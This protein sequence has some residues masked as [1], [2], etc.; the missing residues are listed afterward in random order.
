MPKRTSFPQ[1]I[2][3]FDFGMRH[4]GMAVGQLIT[5]SATSLNPIQARDGIP[6]WAELD[7]IIKQWP[8]DSIVIGVPF[9]MDETEQTITFAARKFA[10]RLHERYQLPVYEVDERLTTVEAKQQLY[11]SGKCRGKSLN[12]VD[13][14]AAKLIVEDWLRNPSSEFFH[15]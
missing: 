3:G 6:D 2:L 15:D 7:A 1:C 5:K 9:N 4:I 13:S 12:H 10:R 14:M 11:D 8:V